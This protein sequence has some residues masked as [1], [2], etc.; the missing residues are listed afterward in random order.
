MDGNGRVIEPATLAAVAPNMAARV[1]PIVHDMLDAGF[2]VGDELMPHDLLQRLEQKRM[3]LWVAVSTGGKPVAALLT[4]LVRM[5]SGLYCRMTQCGG[6]AL[7]TWRHMH[8][9]IEEYA[10]AEGCVKVTLGGRRGWE[11]VLPGYSATFV[12]LE[13]VLG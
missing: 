8:E 13:K 11:K 7:E 5:R 6:E 9:S 3:V 2:A 1:L 10:R 12:T 4:E